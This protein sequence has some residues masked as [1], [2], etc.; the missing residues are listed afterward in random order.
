[1]K[2]TG[3][4][5]RIVITSSFGA[6]D[7]P[8]PTGLKWSTLNVDESSRKERAKMGAF[9]FYEQSKMVSRSV[10]RCEYKMIL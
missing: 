3:H 4:K 5:A 9:A 8:R 6:N 1:M 2:L 7:A 10:D